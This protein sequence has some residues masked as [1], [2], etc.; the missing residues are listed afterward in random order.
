MSVTLK[1][2]AGTG[3]ISHHCLPGSNR[4]GPDQRQNPGK[5]AEQGTGDGLCE[6]RTF[7]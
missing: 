1:D 7:Q 2:I 4:P 5:N 3:H 6:D